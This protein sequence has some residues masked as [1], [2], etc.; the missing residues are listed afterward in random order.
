MLIENISRHKRDIIHYVLANVKNISTF[1]LKLSR[2]MMRTSSGKI[3]PPFINIFSD[4]TRGK[5]SHII[6]LHS[7]TEF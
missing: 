1:L 6:S 2:T 7:I 3:L 4:I 5:K